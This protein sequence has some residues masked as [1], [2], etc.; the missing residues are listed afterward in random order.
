MAEYEVAN[1]GRDHTRTDGRFVLE[2]E[3]QGISE[4]LHFDKQGTDKRFSFTAA[5]YNYLQV[6]TSVP[7]VVVELG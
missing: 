3:D 7:G 2:I 6:A 5:I 4:E 1:S